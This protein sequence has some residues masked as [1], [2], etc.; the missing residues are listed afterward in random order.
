MIIYKN[1]TLEYLLRK[2]INMYFYYNQILG[3]NQKVN[4]KM[5]ELIPVTLLKRFILKKASNY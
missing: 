4:K 1:K 5:K 3:T 2:I